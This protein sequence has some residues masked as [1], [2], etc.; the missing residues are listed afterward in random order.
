MKVIVGLSGG[1][2]S[3]LSAY[4]LQ[5]QGYE[6]EALFMKNWEEDR[7]EC[8]IAEDLRDAMAICQQLNIPLHIEDFSAQYKDL[9]FAHFLR[10]YRAG[11][12]PNPDILCNKEI[13]FTVFLEQ[14]KRL[15][16]EKIA[17]GHYAG[18]R[19][20]DNT[21]KL[22]RGIDN[23]KD[24]SYF[25]YALNQA[26][27]S[28]TLF[29][30]H[31]WD[32]TA[33]RSKAASFGLRTHNKKDSVGICF[34]GKRSFHDFLS[35][36]ISGQSGDIINDKQQVIGQHNGLAFYTIGQRKGLGIGGIAGHD[37]S[38]WMVVEK[39]IQNNRLIV[40]PEKDAIHFHNHLEASE[41]T[42]IAGVPS[43][44]KL[45]ARIRHR[46]ALQN[47][48]IIH[49]ERDKMQ[50]QFEKP[51]RAISPGQSVVLY[52]GDVCL[53]GGVIDSRW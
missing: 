32:K 37:G 11:R 48:Q 28:Q 52:E 33:V 10:E 18:I 35:G 24:Q 43:T 46:Q 53:G 1:V 29:P 45:Q 49:I 15:G 51:Q 39:D 26:Q 7:E 8:P 38:P 20:R 31:D 5:Q 3:S 44:K 50:I 34:I 22:L 23:D 40:A 19:K 6:V 25:L 17:T 12:T 4:L 27:L 13:K 42:W 30:L 14:A 16:A 41:L 21:Y 9:V 47:C 2:D 36:Y